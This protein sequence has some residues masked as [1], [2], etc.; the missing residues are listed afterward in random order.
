MVNR[1]LVYT[2]LKSFKE[3]PEGEWWK[4]RFS[5]PKT[6]HRKVDDKQR[7]RIRKLRLKQ[8]MNVEKIAYLLDKEGRPLSRN[9]IIKVIEELGL[10]L[11]SNMKKRNKPRY[12]NFERPKPNEL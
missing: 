9:T 7:E 2:W 4:D 6:I 11:W 1:K 12:K 5:R 8:G 3:N 10:P